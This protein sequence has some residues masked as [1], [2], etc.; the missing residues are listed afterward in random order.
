MQEWF[1]LQAEGTLTGSA[2][3]WM[4]TSRPAEELYDTR[5]DPH[6]IRNLSAEPAHRATLERRRRAV[7]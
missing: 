4:R 2:A 6:Q 1:R 3:L 5:V 7:T